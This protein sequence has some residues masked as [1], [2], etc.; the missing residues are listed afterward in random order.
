LPDQDKTRSAILLAAGVGRRLGGSHDGPKVLLEFG[1]RTL[2]QR[3]MSALATNG[4]ERVSITLGHMGE[5]IRDAAEQDPMGLQLNFVDNPRFREGSLVSLWAQRGIL[6]AG[7]PVLVMDGDVLY[8]S[9]MIAR[10]NEA[11][12]ENV[13]LVDRNI[14]P[15][16]EPVKI[17]FRGETIVDFRK[18]PEHAHDWHGESVG[19]FRF[20]PAMAIRLAE[21]C[22]HYVQAGRGDLE[23]EEAIRD[24]ILADPTR[25]GAADVTDLPWT[26]IDFEAD[27]ARARA[28]ILPQLVD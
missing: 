7:Q 24:L 8:D 4:V 17:C 23:Y 13:L 5:A 19:F 16:D 11:P 15:G 27:V 12:F 22:D 28:E 10:L 9:R 26:E 3:H 6:D 2:L 25:F 14:E 21:R 18:Q 20:S 1:G